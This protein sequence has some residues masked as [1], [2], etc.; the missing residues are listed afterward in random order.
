MYTLENTIKNGQTKHTA[1]IWRKTQ[2]DDKQIKNN[3]EN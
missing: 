3:T 1:S 2:G